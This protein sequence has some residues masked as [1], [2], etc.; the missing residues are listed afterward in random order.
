MEF[1]ELYNHSYSEEL[2]YVAPEEPEVLE[3]LE[4]FK[5][6]KFGIMFHWGA[7]SQWGIVE[8]WALPDEDQSWAWGDVDKDLTG[9]QFKQEYWD[10]IKT[11]NPVRFRPREWAKTAKDAGFKYVLFT[12]K[13][14]DGFC[15]WDTKYSDYK[16]TSPE[17][18]FSRNPRSDICK[19]L[20]DAFRDEG[21]KVHAYFSKPDW[22]SEY[23]WAKGF[24]ENEYMTRNT[25]YRTD[26]HPEIWNKFCE[27]TKNQMLELVRDYGRIECLWLD[28]G[29]VNP[30]NMMDIH[31]SEIMKE[32]REIQPWLMVAD[33]TVGGI[34]ENFIT[35][36]QTVPDRP[37][38]VPWES[39]VTLGT[40]FSFRYDDDYKDAKTVIHM[41]CDI[42]AKGGNLALNIG[43]RPDGRLPHKVYPILADI[44]KW[45][46]KNGYAIYE[47]RPA[48]PYR[49]DNIAY[50]GK[51][52]EIYAI[53]LPDDNDNILP[54]KL[55]LYCDEKVR[56]V[57]FNSR[58]IEFVQDGNTVSVSIPENYE[59]EFAYVLTMQK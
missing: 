29:Q 52:N 54:D 37:I 49:K 19:H 24:S 23:Y 16:I 36:E 18:P 41:L 10:L 5:D 1:N 32:A 34:N 25:S 20:F 26:L 31:L 4:R 11:F 56:R 12:T 44:G 7:Y 39:C 47:T 59:K 15:M 45:L 21:L 48:A 14:H 3:S 38:R 50:T 40:S 8:S 6:R 57:I 13:H 51:G 43:P 42:V 58:D 35:P 55:T 9:E 53:Y 46:N 28:G 27:Y 2:R 22:H 33:R 30:N 17:C